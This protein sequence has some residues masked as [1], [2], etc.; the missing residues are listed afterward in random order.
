MKGIAKRDKKQ[1]TEKKW[2]KQK[3]NRNI[4]FK[5]LKI[6]INK[7]K[8][9]E[10]KKKLYEAQTTKTRDK[11][12]VPTC[13]SIFFHGFLYFFRFSFLFPFSKVQ[14]AHLRGVRNKPEP[15][16]KHWKTPVSHGA[17]YLVRFP[18]FSLFIYIIGVLFLH[19]FRIFQ[20]HIPGSLRPNGDKRNTTHLKPVPNQTSKITKWLWRYQTVAERKPTQYQFSYSMF[21]YSWVGL[22]AK[23]RRHLAAQRGFHRQQLPEAGKSYGLKTGLPSS[24]NMRIT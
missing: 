17:S 16:L 2:K 10:K 4:Y 12:E 14:N 23:A 11:S 13:L 24:W 19:S 22:K 9:R 6:K 5:N 18:F 21:K 8:K 20:N 3:K 15:S 1:T 7:E